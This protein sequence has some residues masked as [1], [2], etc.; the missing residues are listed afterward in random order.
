MTYNCK[1]VV[2]V[3]LLL[4]MIFATANYYL[5]LG[6]LPRF[7]KLLALLG[8]LMVLVYVSRFVPTR[9]EIAEHR[10]KTAEKQQ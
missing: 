2:A 5:D 6:V 7:A 4:Y 3:L 1:R 10:R 8:A 9:E